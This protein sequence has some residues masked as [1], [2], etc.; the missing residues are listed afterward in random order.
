MLLFASKPPDFTLTL[1]EVSAREGVSL[2]YAG[3]LLTILKRAGLVKAVRGRNG[4]YILSRRPEKITLKEIFSALG[5]SLYGR[6]HCQRY[7]EKNKE[8]VHSGDCQIGSIWNTFD[9][10]IQNVLENLT[11]ADI[12]EGKFDP[13]SLSG[14]STQKQ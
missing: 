7:Q 3:K 9:Q 12:A 4:G 6:H 10:Y 13:G 1:P 8:C 14:I 11:L 5:D 2:P